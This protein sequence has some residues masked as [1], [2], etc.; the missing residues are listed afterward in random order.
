MN[1]TLLDVKEVAKMLKLDEQTIYRM[2]EK[3]KDKLN[4]NKLPAMRIGGV[5]RFKR[6]DIEE[7]L[8]N[9]KGK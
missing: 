8:K 3:D 2:V 5:I 9:K 6:E 7:W 1:E 4:G